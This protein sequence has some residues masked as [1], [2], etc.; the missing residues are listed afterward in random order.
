MYNEEGILLDVGTVGALAAK[1]ELDASAVCK[2]CNRIY[3][4]TGTLDNKR[5][6]FRYEED[7]F[8]DEDFL[9]VKETPKSKRKGFAIKGYF[10]DTGIEIFNFSSAK[11]AAEK[12]GFCSRSICNCASG[13]YKYAGKV[14]GRKI[15]WK[16][17]E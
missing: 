14:D 1:Y 15:T 2:V 6:I 3:N 12:T 9:K 11:E 7:T 8:T 5:L 10:L 17:I 13:N 16:Y 4:Y